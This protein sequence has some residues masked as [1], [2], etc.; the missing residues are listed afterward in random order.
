MEVRQNNKLRFKRI[1]TESYTLD[2]RPQVMGIGPDVPQ[3]RMAFLGEAPGKDEEREQTPFVGK[4]GRY[5][6]A[7]LK[8]CGIYSDGCYFTNV[9]DRRPDGNEIK[10]TAAQEAIKRQ[11]KQAWAELAWLAER[12]V[13][14]VVALGNTAKAFFGIKESITKC[15]GSIYEVS[16]NWEGLVTDP[17]N[18]PYDFVVIPTYH[19]AFIMRGKGKQK[20]TEEMR[21]DLKLSWLADLEKAHEVATRG[22]QRAV[23]RFVT[24]P[25]IDQVSA[26]CQQVIADKSYVAVDIETSGFNPTVDKV[27]CIGMATSAEDGLCVP[28]YRT[29][30]DVPRGTRYWTPGE[31]E[32]VKLWLEKVF[33]PCPLIFQNA[34]FDVGYLQQA[35]WQIHADNVAHDTLLA[36]H[37]IA[38]ELPHNLG[39]ITSIYGATPYWKDDFL[40]RDT[41]IWEMDF[42]DLQTYNLRDCIVLH[43]VMPPMLKDIEEFDVNVAYQESLSLIG[44]V[45]EMQQT[46]ALISVGR[47]NKWKKNFREEVDSLREQM[48]ELGSLPQNFSFSLADV[49]LFLYGIKA[50]KHEAAADWEKHREGTAVR[51][52]KRE[53]HEMV[54]AIRPL[55]HHQYRGH[56]TDNDQPSLDKAGIT[57]LR[58][59][60]SNRLAQLNNMK[61][62]TSDHDSEQAGLEKFVRWLDLY[63]K[64]KKVEKAEGMF[65]DLPV[66]RDGRIH[67]QLLIFGT[68]TGRMS[69]KSPNLQQWNKD[70]GADEGI[71][72]II[73]APKGYRIVAADYSN[74]E[75]RIMAYETQ[76]KRLLEIVE[77]GLNQ[78]DENTKALFGIDESHPK[79]K[80][81]RAAAKTYQFASQYGAGDSKILQSLTL[82]VPEANFTSAD[83]RKMRANFEYTYK[84]WAAWVKR[85]R[86]AVKNSK[87]SVTAFGRKRIL[88]GND[89]EIKNQCLNTPIQ[90][91]A[92][93]IINRALVRIWRRL[94]EQKMRSRLQM[95]IHDELRFEVAEDELEEVASIVREEME[96]PVDYRGKQVV[97][98]VNV[99]VGPDWFHLEE[100]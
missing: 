33:A 20:K 53:L 50:S 95:Q 6:H 1:V 81:Y 32:Q 14:V 5:L 18:E 49:T 8:E 45:L 83:V 13:R 62:R 3:I 56:F 71:R 38:A 73:V 75:V 12:G 40:T 87:V 17:A 39:Y 55:W 93:S 78:H 100:L 36:H 35:G 57:G 80:T 19:P 90:G 66:R 29:G 46:G 98:P 41:T 37:S 68:A 72:E 43:Q 70:A 15:R 91:G 22:Y 64:W 77:G 60:A 2:D 42:L 7:H 28:F 79:W 85:T 30:E 96:R 26:F 58:I 59:F 9:I 74:L 92:A 31:E 23:E 84:G 25:T 99:E 65:R 89:Y 63:A 47:W 54:E 11:N 86:E 4:A 44:P 10:T 61:R 51:E 24:G 97:F 34:V 21:S 69:C 88:Y 67:P 27:I 48:I 52:A 76:D 94:R 16:L 82:A